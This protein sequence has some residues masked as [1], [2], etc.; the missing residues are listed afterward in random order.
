MPG[1]KSDHFVFYQTVPDE[2][3]YIDGNIEQKIF[4][5]IGHQ[6]D[7]KLS[8]L[9][10]AGFRRS[11]DIIY[12]PNC[13]ACNACI[14]SRINVDDFDFS[15]KSVRRILNKNSDLSIKIDHEINAEHAYAL[16]KTYQEERHTDGDMSFMSF[17]EFYL[18]F[19]EKRPYSKRI[20]FYDEETLIAL[21]LYDLLEDGASAVYSIFDPKCPKR[22]LGKFVVYYLLKELKT[23]ENQY[24]YLGYWIEQSPAMSYKGSFDALEILKYGQGWIKKP[25]E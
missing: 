24:L 21:L 14:P 7:A 17:D 22:S 6:D 9:T 15:K 25:L 8:L 5:E 4:T 20:A 19:F 1:Y 23:K 18:M 13:E 16:F 11:H 2:C 12:R 10:K 3:P